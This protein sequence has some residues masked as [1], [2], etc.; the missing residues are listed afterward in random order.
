MTLIDEY[1][2]ESIKYSKKFGDNTIVL[3]QVGHF[4]D[5][6]SHWDLTDTWIAA[7]TDPIW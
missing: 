1:L 4:Y 2:D 3:M 7:S 6:N 5:S